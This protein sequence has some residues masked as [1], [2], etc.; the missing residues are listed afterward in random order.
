VPVQDH[1]IIGDGGRFVSLRRDQG[2]LFS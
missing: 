1:V 2:S